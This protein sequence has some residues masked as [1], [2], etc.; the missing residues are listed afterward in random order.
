MLT[1]AG[2]VARDTF[3]RGP[4]IHTND[5]MMK[6]GLVVGG[7]TKIKVII[8]GGIVT[9]MT[10]ISLANVLR[11]MTMIVPARRN[12]HDDADRNY[13]RYDSDHHHNH[14]HIMFIKYLAA[15]TCQ[16]SI[17]VGTNATCQNKIGK[18]SSIGLSSGD[19]VGRKTTRTC[20]ACH[21]RSSTMSASPPVW[22][23][24]LSM[25]TTSPSSNQLF[26]S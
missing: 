2:R 18:M 24:A 6:I 1:M 21:S 13:K 4:R 7:T 22:M 8:Q 14:R 9:L 12:D 17:P 16:F 3:I 20:I 5:D 11:M 15:K 25:M 23:E 19:L 10:K 26:R